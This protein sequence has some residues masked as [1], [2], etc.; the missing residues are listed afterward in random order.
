MWWILTDAYIGWK[1]KLTIDRG[2][3]HV[4]VGQLAGRINGRET[5]IVQYK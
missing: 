2:G 1:R 3:Y 5:D 4:R